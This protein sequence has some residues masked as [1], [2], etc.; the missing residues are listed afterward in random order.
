MDFLI[1]LVLFP[2]NTKITNIIHSEVT[3]KFRLKV[4]QMN[5]FL[6]PKKTSEN[7]RFFD[8][9][10]EYAQPAITCSKLTI[11]TLE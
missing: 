9:S 4:D 11:E 3:Q 5:S 8:F 1:N 6:F 2:I 10:S 7:L